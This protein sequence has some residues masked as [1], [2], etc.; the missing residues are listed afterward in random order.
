MA[1]TQDKNFNLI[2]TLGVTAGIKRDGTTFDSREYSDGTWC[3]FQRGV[4]KKM[5]GYR[6]MFRMPD[7]VPRGMIANPY[8]GLNYMFIGYNNG[9]K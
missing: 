6:Q 3:R 2:Y 4:P 7:G 9:E 1:D 5:G 8:N